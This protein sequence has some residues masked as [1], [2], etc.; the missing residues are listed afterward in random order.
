MWQNSYD[1]SRL[2]KTEQ[3]QL[4][5]QQRIDDVVVWKASTPEFMLR[6]G[7]FAV[8][9]H[10]GLTVYIKQER[11]PKLNESYTALSWYKAL[12]KPIVVAN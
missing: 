3:Q 6:Y 11:Y 10:S 9:R 8:E 2:L 7:G 5:L 1:Y 12:R 4:Q